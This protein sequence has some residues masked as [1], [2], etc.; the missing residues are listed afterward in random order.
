MYQAMD[1]VQGYTFIEAAVLRSIVLRYTGAPIPTLVSFFFPFVYL[2]ISIFPT[3]FCTIA[4][5]SLYG[6]DVV[7]F[8]LPDGVFLPFV[9]TCWIFDIRLCENSYN[10]SV[11]DI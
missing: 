3:I 10:Q 11:K 6:E 1:I 8:F 9:T 2:E 7:R 4:V 5:F